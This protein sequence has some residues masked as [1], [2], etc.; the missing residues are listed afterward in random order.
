[1]GR[2]RSFDKDVYLQSV[3]DDLFKD[4]TAEEGSAL[5]TSA[6]SIANAADITVTLADVL[7]PLNYILPTAAEHAS[8]A[9]AEGAGSRLDELTPPDGP[10]DMKSISSPLL[11]LTRM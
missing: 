4:L 3:L 8:W 11:T 10:G 6:D 1:M 2:G 7:N 9:Q 5:F